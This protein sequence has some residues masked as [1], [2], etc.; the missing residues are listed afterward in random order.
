MFFSEFCEISKSTFFTEH[1][2]TTASTL[3]NNFDVHAQKCC[4]GKTLWENQKKQ[5]HTQVSHSFKNSLAKKKFCGVREG[6]DNVSLEIK[7]C[8]WSQRSFVF[9]QL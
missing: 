3:R 1:P 8:N 5:S 2:R 7:S 9:M 6:N 4:K